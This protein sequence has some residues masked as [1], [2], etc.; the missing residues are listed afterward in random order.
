I[1]QPTASR[2]DG[3]PRGA[4]KGQPCTGTAGLQRPLSWG[5]SSASSPRCFRRTSRSASR[6]CLCGCCQS[7]RGR[8]WSTAFGRGGCTRYNGGE[9]D[10]KGRGGVLRFDLAIALAALAGTMLWVEHGHR[11]YIETPAGMA[12]AVSAGEVA[13]SAELGGRTT[14]TATMSSPLNP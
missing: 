12:L 4:A 1:R 8:T 13:D 2:W 9:W 14:A 3:R 7:W 11:V 5:R 10:R 6:S